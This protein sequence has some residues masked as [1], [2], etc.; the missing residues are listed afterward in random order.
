MEYKVT[1]YRRC[2]GKSDYI[3][4]YNIFSNFIK[5]EKGII[6]LQ[7]FYPTYG[8]AKIAKILMFD[9]LK[10]LVSHLNQRDIKY[11]HDDYSLLINGHGGPY[12]YSV[13]IEECDTQC[14]QLKT[15]EIKQNISIWTILVN[16]I[17]RIFYKL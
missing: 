12:R 3:S 14:S 4:D 7:N 10:D 15:P 1:V 17:K 2:L 8:K 5:T 13:E 6:L 9:E 16:K 11:I